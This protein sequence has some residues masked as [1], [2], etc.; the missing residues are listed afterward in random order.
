MDV[1]QIEEHMEVVGSDGTHVGIVDKVEGEQIK[2]TRHDSQAEGEHH[3][4][5]LSS[6]ASVGEFVT[7]STSAENVKTN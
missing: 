2:L 7:L 1:A 4:I 3:Y 5:P 6:V